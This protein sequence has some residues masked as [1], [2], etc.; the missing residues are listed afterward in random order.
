M[1]IQ[2]IHGNERRHSLFVPAIQGAV[3][4]AGAGLVGKYAL[5]LTL[6]EKLDEKY[7]DRIAEIEREKTTYNAHTKKFLHGIT[8]KI[9]K[10]PAEDEFVKMFDGM[11]KGDTMDQARIRQAI[12]NLEKNSPEFVPAFKN[13]CRKSL[14]SADN[15]AKQAVQVYNIFTKHIR[16]TGFFLATGAI[17]GTFIA[18]A[19]DIM[20]TDIKPLSDN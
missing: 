9:K 10:S 11:K 14:E 13:L 17:A 4:G 6:E 3:I 19:H 16:P 5:P 7:I 8:S 2:Q 15:I 20:K 18:L 1:P 12:L